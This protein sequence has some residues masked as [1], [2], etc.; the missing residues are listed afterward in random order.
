MWRLCSLLTVLRSGGNHH[1]D[2]STKVI[3]TVMFQAT[4]VRIY[5][6]VFGGEINK[7]TVLAGSHLNG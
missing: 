7:T 1:R 3:I 2:Y 4:L 6:M 5:F